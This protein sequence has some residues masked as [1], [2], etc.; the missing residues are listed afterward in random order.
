MAGFSLQGL[1][2]SFTQPPQ[3]AD[4]LPQYPPEVREEAMR[5]AREQVEA[6]GGMGDN[7]VLIRY[8]NQFAPQVMREWQMQNAR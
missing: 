2:E 3:L 5:R 8:Y 6:A 4:L 1:M 7:R